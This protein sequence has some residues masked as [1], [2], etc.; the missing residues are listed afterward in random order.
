MSARVAPY[1]IN[2]VEFSIAGISIKDGLVSAEIAPEGPAFADELGADG[3]VCRYA[4]NERRHTMNVTLKGSSEENA[5]LSVLH[6]LDVASTNG[7][8]IVP[9]FLRDG[10][11]T[12][13]ISTDSAWITQL[14]TKSFGASAGDCVW[15][16]RC[17][18]SSPLNAVIGGN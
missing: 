2:A 11:G 1:N 9:M 6:G 14:P 4:T 3:L 7:A 8:G 12:S 15:N 5:K 16:I 13:L 10:N 18:L 17:V